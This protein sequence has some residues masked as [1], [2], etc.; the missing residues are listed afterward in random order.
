[1]QCVAHLWS[2][3]KRKGKIAGIFVEVGAVGDLAQLEY[4]LRT[5]FGRACELSRLQAKPRCV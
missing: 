2:G 3:E 5:G 1:M 4:G